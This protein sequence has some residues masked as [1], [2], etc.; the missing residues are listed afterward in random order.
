LFEGEKH[1]LVADVET[2]E[3]GQKQIEVI[4]IEKQLTAKLGAM[5]SNASGSAIALEVKEPV[6]FL[7]APISAC[8]NS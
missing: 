3:K 6:Y 1:S 7:L 5:S 4:A 2:I 8:A